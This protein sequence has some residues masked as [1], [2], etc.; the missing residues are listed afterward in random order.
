MLKTEIASL[1]VSRT[2]KFEEQRTDNT[3]IDAD[4]LYNN[5]ESGILNHS[6]L[7]RALRDRPTNEDSIRGV[8]V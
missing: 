1:D 2:V 3:I 7:G 4:D 8:T 5:C 6:V